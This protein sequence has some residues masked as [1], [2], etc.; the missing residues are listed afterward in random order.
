LPVYPF[1]A[2]QNP[3]LRAVGS[4]PRPWL[5]TPL[6]LREP[7]AW[8]C[9]PDARPLSGSSTSVW[10]SI[11]TNVLRAAGRR[12]RRVC[13]GGP[14][15]LYANGS[16]RPLRRGIISRATHCKQK[17]NAFCVHAM[18]AIPVC[19]RQFHDVGAACHT[20]IVHEDVD[21]PECRLDGPCAQ[22]PADRQ[23]Q[24]APPERDV[25]LT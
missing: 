17:N 22:Y 13:I 23:R 2:L 25:A 8:A 10:D 6:R 12:S 20:G 15:T 1:D 24:P 7:A 18:N 3:C 11:G 14:T 5:S 19:F 4:R 9:G 16:K 21:L